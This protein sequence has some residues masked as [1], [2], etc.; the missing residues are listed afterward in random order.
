VSPTSEVP[1]A[2]S[3]LRWHQL[4]NDATYQVIN[5][6]QSGLSS[7]WKTKLELPAQRNYNYTVTA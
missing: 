2:G 1:G 6:Q 4:P 5:Y 7:G 3:A